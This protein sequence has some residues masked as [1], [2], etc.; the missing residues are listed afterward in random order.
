MKGDR[1]TKDRFEQTLGALNPIGHVMIAFAD[2][3]TA[4]EARSALLKA[5][6]GEDDAYTY[7]S[8]ELEP[9]LDE[10]LRAASGASGFGYESTLMRRYLALAQEDVGWLVVYA[11]RDERAEH[12]AEVARRFVARCAVRYHLLASED[13]I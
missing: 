2:D 7:T 4:G 11:P 8:A 1:M 3:R 6:F 10:M 5:G 9:R 13:L 12:V